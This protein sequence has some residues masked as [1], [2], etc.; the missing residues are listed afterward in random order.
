MPSV[1]G[2]LPSENGLRFINA[3]PH[4][5]NIEVDVP[6]FGT[7]PIGDASNGLCGGMV[8]TVRDVFEAGLQPLEDPQPDRGTPLFDY[9]VRRLFDSFDLPGGVLKYFEWMNTPDGDTSL[10]VAVRRGVAWKTLREEWPKV[11][12][13]IDAGHPSPLGLVTVESGNPQDLGKNHQVLAYRYDLIRDVL[14]L[15]VYDPNTERSR[16]DDAFLRLHV[17]DPTKATPIQHTIQ[18]GEPIRGFFRADYTRRDPRS[19]FPPTP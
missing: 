2:F 19:L 16:A 5:P 18:I 8:F 10:W 14:T 9:I 3:W 17:E 1:P 13:D 11:R 4:E 15:H 7:I 12:A 6:P